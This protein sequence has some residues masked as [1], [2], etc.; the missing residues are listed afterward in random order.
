[1]DKIV[2]ALIKAREAVKRA[3][4]PRTVASFEEVSLL[5]KKKGV[6]SVTVELA[7]YTT[8]AGL[9]KLTVDYIGAGKKKYV[10]R[11]EVLRTIEDPDTDDMLMQEMKKLFPSIKERA[12]KLKNDLG[13]VVMIPE[14]FVKVFA[15]TPPHAQPAQTQLSEQ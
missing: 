9:H 7:C 11:R 3:V 1:M 13:V 2:A 5:F 10:V 8:L 14:Q 12:E 4:L 15:T 6:T